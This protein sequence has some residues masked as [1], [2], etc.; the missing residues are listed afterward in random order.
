[1]GII[2][3]IKSEFKSISIEPAVFF[4]L[5]GRLIIDGAQLQTNL[6]I[7]KICNLELNYS[8]EICSN[9]T[10]DVYEDYN[11]EVQKGVATIQTVAMYLGGRVKG[12]QLI[13]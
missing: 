9:L 1:M 7:W 11:V 5:C 12:W 10:L 3:K 8:S 4:Y 6:M 13:D 2:N